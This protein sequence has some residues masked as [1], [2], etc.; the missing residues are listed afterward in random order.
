MN[1]HFLAFGTAFAALMGGFGADAQ[2]ASGDA[3][4]QLAPLRRA[5]ETL[6]VTG[7][8]GRVQ[9]LRVALHEWTLVAG[10]DIARFP[11]D[12][13]L[14]V[15]LRAG[16]VT[17]TIDGQSMARSEGEFW[18]VP[19]GKTMALRVTTEM[20]TIATTSVSSP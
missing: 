8:D 2:L 9:A 20:A 5:D 7:R 14:L 1:H 19:A 10:R 13:N 15:Q 18:V 17:T 6:A 4:E 11:A 16:R 3:A 12:G